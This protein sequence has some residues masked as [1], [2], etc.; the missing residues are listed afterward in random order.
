MNAADRDAFMR[1]LDKAQ[2]SDAFWVALQ[3]PAQQE[4]FA[5]VSHAQWFEH[6][7][8]IAKIHGLDL[9]RLMDVRKKAVAGVIYG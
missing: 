2:M 4:Q 6:V 5:Q 8:A 1:G 9:D 3:S 7:V